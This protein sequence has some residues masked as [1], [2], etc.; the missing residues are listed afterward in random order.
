MARNFISGKD[1]KAVPKKVIRE[2]AEKYRKEVEKELL[3]EGYKSF[4]DFGSGFP[5]LSIHYAR[6]FAPVCDN[7][8]ELR[9]RM[10]IVNAIDIFHK[11]EYTGL[12]P[13]FEKEAKE[14]GFKNMDEV[15]E[16]YGKPHGYDPYMFNVLSSHYKSLSSMINSFKTLGDKCKFFS[17][18]PKRLANRIEAEKYRH[19]HCDQAIRKALLIICLQGK[20]NYNR[21]NEELKKDGLEIA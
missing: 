14:M 7:F 16:K 18:T 5:N 3:K 11:P 6:F 1:G 4:E 13:D 10:S 2:K 21:F 17:I 20:E 19:M 15:A 9:M 12:N 8:N